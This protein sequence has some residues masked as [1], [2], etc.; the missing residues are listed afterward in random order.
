M[1]EKKK[2]KNGKKVL[3]VAS[4]AKENITI[5]NI[6][7]VPQVDA[8]IYMDTKNPGI[9]KLVNGHKIGSLSDIHSIVDYAK[10]INP[11][12]VLVTTT[13]TLSLG[14]VDALEVRG[15]KV[16]GPNQMAAKLESDKDFARNLVDKCA[17]YA[18]PKYKICTSA[19]EATK[20]AR[21][22]GWQV[23]VKPLGLMGGLG[24][25]VYGD[26]LHGEDDVKTYI[27]KSFVSA[28]NGRE[29]VLIEEKMEGEEFTIQCL[30]F[31]GHILPTPAVQD[32]KKKLV[33]DRGLNTGGMGSYADSSYLLPFMEQTDYDTA[34][35]IMKQTAQAFKEETSQYFR[36]FLYGQFIITADGV[37]LVEYNFRPGDPEW[38]NTMSVMKNNIVQVIE[39]LFDGEEQQLEFDNQASVCKYI[40][41]PQYP[42]K[43]NE[44][45]NVTF[46]ENKI[47]EKGVQFYYS[48]GL[49]DDGRINVDHERGIVFVAKAES[50]SEAS[51]KVEE[52]I[53]HVNG[54][55]HHRPD[56]GSIEMLNKKKERIQQMRK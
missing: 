42:E 40:V 55:F 35:K 27:K 38:V 7:R 13:K 14:L 19:D 30:V 56:I 53:S 52:A 33:G 8:F 11:D 48:C 3:I 43:L 17:S 46:D 1:A 25:K 44:V 15:L 37:K 22:L 32:F 2:Q 47:W 34:L 4:W 54:D 5:E 50:I 10:K 31:D 18:N 51:E 39:G 45:L 29:N 16:F 28:R 36:G 41:P 9:I 26:Q 6:I 12:L 20:F 21:D 23:A 24:V 49:D